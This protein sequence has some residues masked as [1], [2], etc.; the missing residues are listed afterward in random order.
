M[1]IPHTLSTQDTLVCSTFST[2]VILEG[3]LV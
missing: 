1:L 2:P 3:P